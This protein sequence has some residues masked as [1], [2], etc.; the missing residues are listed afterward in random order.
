[1]KK[2]I[3]PDRACQLAYQLA[4]PV[5]VLVLGLTLVFCPDTATALISKL[6]G[7]MLTIVGIVFGITAII[8]RDNAVKKGI[9][10]VAFA[11]VGG[12]LTAN[13]LVLAAWIGRLL[14]LLLAARGIRDLTLCASMGYSRILALIT[15]GAGIVLILLPLTTSRLVFIL[16]GLALLALGVGM[17]LDRLKQ[18][19]YLPK[20]DDNII[21]AL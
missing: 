10:A 6:L 4:S 21:D 5:A 8:D 20:G 11:C 16:C 2:N 15:T 7:W 13:P 17:T 19:R 9:T 3:F 18:M 12:W 14:G 1:M